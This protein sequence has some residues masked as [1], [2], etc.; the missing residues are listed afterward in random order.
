MGSCLRLPGWHQV[1]SSGLVIRTLVLVVVAIVMSLLTTLAPAAASQRSYT[2]CE[3]ACTVEEWLTLERCQ[4]MDE[5]D[6]GVVEDWEED[7]FYWDLPD[8]NNDGEQGTQGDQD[9][10]QAYCNEL[11]TAGEPDPEP[12]PDASL[13]ALISLLI[14][15]LQDILAGL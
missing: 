6:S 5:D 15:I 11:L 9:I 7:H 12:T 8:F 3:T 13:A 1:R 2:E 10:A 14:S 4:A